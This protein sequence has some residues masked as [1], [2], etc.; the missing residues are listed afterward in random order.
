MQISDIVAAIQNRRV[1]ITDHADAEARGDRLSYGEVYY[2]VL[3]GEL[4]ED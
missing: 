4:I 3:Q 1:R 2:S